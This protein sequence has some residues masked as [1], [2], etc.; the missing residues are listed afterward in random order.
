MSFDRNQSAGYVVNYLARSF[1]QALFRRIRPHGV[2]TGQFPVL[3]ALWEREGV[4]QTQLAENLAVEQPT[5]A[6]TLKRMER[7][8]L[9]QRVPDPEDRRQSRIHLTPRGREL[10]EVLTGCAN[11][12]NA[13]A[14]A[15]FS[16][17]ERDTFLALA[18]RIVR[19]LERD[20]GGET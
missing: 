2:T 16:A 5:M 9:I 10:E 12:A 19:N 8:A 4:T 1:A 3:L 20:A 13:A 11:D 17:E 15:G 14:L 6:N 18:R 7:D